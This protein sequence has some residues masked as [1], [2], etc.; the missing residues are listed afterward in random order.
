MQALKELGIECTYYA[1]EIDKY[2][3]LI[4]KKNHPD[5][6]HIGDI[7]NVKASDLPKIDLLIGGSPCQN[8]SIA[9]NGKGL[10]G[11]QSSLFYE[12]LRLK[13]ELKPK[14]FILEN[15]ASMKKAD[16]DAITKLMGVS[17][18][19][20]NSALLTAQNRKRY[21]RT[22]SL[23][24]QPMDKGILLKDI[25]ED[26]VDEKYYLK[27]EYL[28]KL[29]F[30]KKRNLAKG[31]GFGVQLLDDNKEKYP[32][33]RT[34]QDKNMA[35]LKQVG[36][37]GQNKRQDRIYNPD[38]KSATLAG[39]AGGMGAKTGLCAIAQRGR[40]IVDGVRKDE[41]GATC[42][43]QLETSFSEKSNC[44]STVQ[45]DSMVLEGVRIR[46]LTLLECE[47]L[48]GLPDGYTEGVSNT[49]RY[50]MI[51]NGFTIPVIKH[52]LGGLNEQ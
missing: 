18:A 34:S 15:V 29:I 44:L 6:I 41:K 50:R 13:E 47:R 33:L 3:M 35:Y 1:S 30:H 4:A 12:Y 10:E 28:E 37:L 49:Q 21:Y 39:N 5:I 31:N 36:H 38:G 23:I 19:M 25:L 24:M 16:R 48:Q 20:I 40:N 9:G 2:A 14:H 22:D 8:L 42:T 26:K 45:K 7:M 27:Q 46:K 43:Q 17:P 32:A 52:L 11:E 51:G